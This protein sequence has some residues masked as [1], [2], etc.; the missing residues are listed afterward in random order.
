MS[1]NL[2]FAT[3]SLRAAVSM[4]L[5]PL[6]VIGCTGLLWL[7]TCLFFYAMLLEARED[8]YDG[9]V[10]HARQLVTALERDI[11]RSIELYEL[12]LSAAAQGAT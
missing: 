1:R 12:S 10:R 9:E 6:G 8:A 7:C 3:R 5:T 4:V 11:L 2:K